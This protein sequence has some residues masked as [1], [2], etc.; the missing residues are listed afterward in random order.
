MNREEFH[1]I[2]GAD[3]Y[4]VTRELKVEDDRLIVKQTYDA[5]PMLVAAAAERAATSG[6]RWGE[7]RKVGTIPMAVYA[8]SLTLS[9]QERQKYLLGWLREN[10]KFVTFDK[11]LKA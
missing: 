8:Q 4:G 11:F 2:E 3:G 9:N 10:S 7:M 5:E 6:Q 1:V